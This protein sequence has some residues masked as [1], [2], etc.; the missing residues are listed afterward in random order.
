MDVYICFNCG[1]PIIF[2]YPWHQIYHIPSGWHCWDSKKG[3]C[4]ALC[5]FEFTTDKT[6]RV[7][8][9]K[10][11]EKIFEKHGPD[12]H[13]KPPMRFVKEMWKQGKADVIHDI[14]GVLVDRE[15]NF[16]NQLIKKIAMSDEWDRYFQV[17]KQFPLPR[18]A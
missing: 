6:T 2:R 10:K 11:F 13:E 18:K 15:T 17:R 3:G 4:S 12:E 5:C 8:D 7:K 9:R 16:S 14:L 1:W